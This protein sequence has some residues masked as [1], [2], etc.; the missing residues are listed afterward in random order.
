MGGRRCPPALRPDGD[1]DRF[2]AQ[3]Q[4]GVAVARIARLEYA[5]ASAGLEQREEG[6]RESGRRPRH[7]EDPIDL[8]AFTLRESPTQRVDAGGVGVAELLVEMG[9]HGLPSEGGQRRRRLTDLEMQ[10]SM[11]RR[12]QPCGLAAHRHRMERRHCGGADSGL[13][14]LPIVASR[15]DRAPIPQFVPTLQCSDVRL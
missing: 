7:D 6:E 3:R 13:D 11:P 2:D 4:Q 9:A 5:D 10:D 8:D 12:L 15:C 14:H 1:G